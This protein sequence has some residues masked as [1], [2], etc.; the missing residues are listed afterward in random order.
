MMSST[1]STVR[2]SK[3]ASLGWLGLSAAVVL[4]NTACPGTETPGCQGNDDCASDEICSAGACV[5][6]NAPTDGGPADGGLPTL[7]DGG[8]ADGGGTPL[9][10]GGATDGGTIDVDSGTEPDPEPGAACIPNGDGRITSAETPVVLGAN[11]RFTVSGSTENPVTVDLV[12]TLE[13]D[14]RVWTLNESFEGDREVELGATANSGFWFSP[15]FP[16]ADYVAALDG[17]SETY[18]AFRRDGA[19][20]YLLGVAS[21]DEATD[22]LLTYDPPVVALSMPLE[23]GSTFSS[24]TTVSG[25]FE[26]NSFYTSTDTHVMTVYERGVLRTFSGDID[27]LRMRL[28]LEVVIPILIFPFSLTYRYVRH[29]FLTECL[30]QVAYV[31][32]DVDEVED[33]FTS[34]VEV[35]RLGWAPP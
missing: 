22:T 26:G 23:V 27:V 20:L 14:T 21:A 33:N 9:A 15:S 29:S 25:K 13:G 31:A 30:G 3:C 6:P 2:V 7:D 28:E 11:P 12:G 19:T 34:A 18:G 17:D 8:L 10:D 16:T 5:D 4:L 32:S 35:R 24:E 1:S